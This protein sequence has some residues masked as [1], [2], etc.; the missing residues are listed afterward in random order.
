MCAINAVEWAG[1]VERDGGFEEVR[2][3]WEFEAM[4][5]G[6]V[7]RLIKVVKGVG[8]RVGEL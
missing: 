1:E 4:G 7:E 3:G 6:D 2:E 8:D 5:A